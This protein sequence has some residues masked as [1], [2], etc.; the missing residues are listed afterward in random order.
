MSASAVLRVQCCLVRMNLDMSMLQVHESAMELTSY[1]VQFRENGERRTS[2]VCLQSLR[3]G[4]GTHHT[5]CRQEVAGVGSL[6]NGVIAR[7]GKDHPELKRIEAL[8]STITRDLL[9]HLIREEQTLFPYIARVEEAVRQK[10][11]VSWPR[12]GTVE[13]PIR[14]MVLEHDQTDEELKEIGRPSNDYTPPSTATEDYAH[15]Y[16]TRCSSG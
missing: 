1:A 4:S 5:L 11:A 6:F 10:I 7:H 12:F 13:N 14:T 15:L 9:M 3:R 8:F 2:H 16:G